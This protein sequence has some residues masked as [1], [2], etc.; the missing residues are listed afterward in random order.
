MELCNYGGKVT[1]NWKLRHFFINN[2]VRQFL[3]NG[4]CSDPIFSRSNYS[5]SKCFWNIRDKGMRRLH[6]HFYVISSN[7]SEAFRA[8]KSRHFFINNS[9][10]PCLLSIIITYWLPPAL[11]VDGVPSPLCLKVYRYALRLPD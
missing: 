1:V 8:Q 3:S 2:P 9:V 10:C 5:I 4:L 7:R 11:G 6:T